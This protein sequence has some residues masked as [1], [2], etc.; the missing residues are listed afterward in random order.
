MPRRFCHGYGISKSTV[1]LGWAEIWRDRWTK[2]TRCWEA[3]RGCVQDGWLWLE[4]WFWWQFAAPF[5]CWVGWG[6]SALPENEHISFEKW[7]DW[8]T[9]IYF[10][11]RYN[12]L[13]TGDVYFLVIRGRSVPLALEVHHGRIGKMRRSSATS[14]KTWRNFKKWID[15]R[16]SDWKKK[17]R[18]LKKWSKRKSKVWKTMKRG[19]RNYKMR[20]VLFFF[21]PP[22]PHTGCSRGGI[23]N[24]FRLG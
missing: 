21:L 2:P 17:I 9:I 11:H 1:P 4:W 3:L 13:F 19:N 12:P 18:I 15:R 24:W 10:P 14:Q 16:A 23:F 20:C 6:G 8:K 22:S 5:F 7:L